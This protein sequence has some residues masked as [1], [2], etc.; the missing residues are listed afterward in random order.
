VWRRA[1]LRRP[2]S[3]LR[4][5]NIAFCLLRGCPAALASAG[6]YRLL[7][8]GLVSSSRPGTFTDA[9]LQAYRAQWSR[10][11]ALRAMIHWYRALRLRP[12]RPPR[13]DAGRTDASRTDASR[14]G[15]GRTGA[16][17]IRV[18]TLLVWGARDRALGRELAAAS[19]AR[20]KHGTLVHLD[21]ASHWLQHEE[22]GRVNALILDHLASGPT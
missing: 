20:C 15:A 14:T 21:E 8:W 17:R 7:V 9:D 16:G 22:P 6:R 3:W 19:I 13:A 12:P 4:C 1:R 2:R 18:P 5:W 10:P 11:G